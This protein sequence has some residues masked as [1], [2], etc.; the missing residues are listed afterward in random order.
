MANISP[1]FKERENTM[2]KQKI[3]CI[4]WPAFLVAGVL[5]MV[6]FAVIDPMDIHWMSEGFD[7][8]RQGFYTIAFF[9]FWAV[10]TVASALSVFLA[11]PS[12]QRESL[13]T[14]HAD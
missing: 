4:A 9:V 12:V 7:L 8:S 3:M 11:Y 13:R 1:E 14:A 10:I 6:V 5:E 2:L